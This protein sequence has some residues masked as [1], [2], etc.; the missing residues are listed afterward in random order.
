MTDRAFDPVESNPFGQLDPNADKVSYEPAQPAPQAA[1]A[2][3]APAADPFANFD[4]NAKD[5][6]YPT[7]ANSTSATGAFVRGAER[8]AL[9]ALGSFPAIGVG[10]EAGAAIGTAVFPGVGTAVGG[11]LGGVAGGL[12]AS[13]AIDTAQN[14]ALS[15]LPES[16]RESI[17]QS[18]RQ[19]Q[20][21]QKEH[22]TA[23]FLGG[24]LPYAVTMKPG[25]L[26]KTAELPENATALQHIMANPATARVFG[27]AVMGGMELGQEAVS[28]NP[29]DWTKVAISTGFGVVFNRPTRIGET[30]TE[31]GAQPARRALGRPEPVSGATAPPAGEAAPAEAPATAEAAPAATAPVRYGVD[32]FTPPAERPVTVADANDLGTMGPGV[33]EETFQGSHQR[34][35]DAR[36]TASEM[37]RTEQAAI[38][39]D[40]E[41]DIHHAARAM[42]P[43]LFSEYDDLKTQQR[44]LQEWDSPLAEAHL[45]ATNAELAE[46]E[47]QIAAAYRRSAEA[48]GAPIHE[49]LTVAKYVDDYSAGRGRDSKDYEQFA[50]NNAPEIEAEF[51]RRKQQHGSETSAEPI[52]EAPGQDQTKA[53]EAGGTTA[54]EPG[55]GRSI[56]DTR[57]GGIQYH[58]SSA[59]DLKPSSDHYSTL[60]YYGQGFYTTDAADVAHGYSKRGSKQTGERNIYE[61]KEKHPLKIFDGETS[62]PDDIRTALKRDTDKS[63]SELD[64][65][66]NDVLAENPKNMRELYDEIREQGT[67]EGLSADT[68]QEIFDGINATL[69]DLGYN[70]MSH[71]GG[72]RTGREPHRVVIYFDPEADLTVRKSTPDEFASKPAAPS[73]AAA[74]TPAVRAIE[75]QRDFIRGDVEKD[76]IA[77]GRPK[78]EAQAAAA[79]IAA[80]YEARA[81]RFQGKLG[82]P[83][84]LYNAEHAEILG[85]G[86]RSEQARPWK[87]RAPAQ[88]ERISLLQFIAQRGGIK[89][90]DPLASDVRST[91]GR[92]NKLIPGFGPLLRKTGIPL[93]R[94]RE[95]AVEAG[96]LPPHSEQ[97]PSTVRSLIDAIHDEEK[98]RTVHAQG[99]ELSGK[100]NGAER[101]DHLHAIEEEL[102]QGLRD[103]SIDPNAIADNVRTRAVEIMD[104]EHERDPVR[105]YEKAE[106][107]LGLFQRDEKQTES[108]EFKKWFAKSAVVDS[109]RTPKVLY[110]ASKEPIESFDA[111]KT[112]DG[113]FHFG[114]APQANM[115]V[116]GEG[117]QLTP[118]YLAIENPRRSKDT[119]GNWRSRIAAAKA[120]GNDGIVYLNRYEGTS[121]E[122]VNKAHEEGINLDKLSDG[123]FKKRFPE[124][125]DSYIAFEPEQIKSAIGNRGTF[126]PNSPRILEQATRGKIALL[127]GRRPIISLMKDANASTFIHETGHEWLEQMRRDA[128][129]E[130]AP[131][132]VK[133]D[134]ATINQWLG[135]EP[136]TENIPTKAHEKFARGFEQYLRE[137]IAPSP[138]LASVFARF[139]QWLTQIYQSLKGLGQ[140]I[141]DDIK[142]VFDRMLSAEPQRTVIA[143]ERAQRPTLTDIH[144][145][146]AAEASPHEADPVADRIYAEKSHYIDN[147]P[148]DIAR[149]H[150]AALEETARLEAEGYEPGQEQPGGAAVDAAG[151]ARPGGAGRAE[152]VGAGAEPDADPTSGAG[153]AQHG[154]V[155]PGRAEPPRESTPVRGAGERSGGGEESQSVPLAA[156]PAAD[157]TLSGNPKWVS[158]EGNIRVENL[159]SVRDIQKAV[160]ESATRVG[161]QGQGSLTA[162]DI[163]QLADAVQLDP[164]KIDEAQLAHLFG[165]V[166]N[167]AAKIIKLRQAIVQSATM[168]SDAMKAVRDDAS[169]ANAAA[170]AQ[171]MMRHDMLQSTLS[172]VTAETGRGLGMGF[173]NLEGWEKA[174]DLNAFMQENTGR[175]LF[176]LKQIAKLGAQLD[177]PGKISKYLRDAQKRSFGKMVLEYWI[178][179]LISG[180]STHVTYAIGNAVLAIE[181]AGPETAIAAALGAAR[182]AS[183]REG[184]RVHIGEVGAQFAGALRGLPGAVEAA[185][186]AIHSGQTTLLPGE[187]ARPL[188][189]FQ[190]DRGLT[191]A[192]SVTDDPVKWREVG[193]Q[194]FAM[195]RGIR[196]GFMAGAALLKAGGVEGAPLIG[197]VY[198]PLG[199]LPDLAIRGVRVLPGVIPGGTQTRIP[200]RSVAAIHSFFRSVGYSMNKSALAYRTAA[201]EGLT[202]TAFD[203]RVGEI[204]QDPSLAVMEASTGQTAQEAARFEAT[205]QTLMGQGGEMVKALG[206]LT[207]ATVDLPFIGEISPLKFV[208]P[209]VHIGA[210]I[211][212]QAIVQRTPVGVLSAEIRADLMGKNG[213]IAQDMAAARMLAG[214]SLALLFG[215]LAMQG[216]ASGSGPKE[217]AKQAMWKLAGNQAH[218][219]RIGDVWYDV[220]RLGP[221]GMLM[222]MA[223]DM[224]EV[225]HDAEKGEYMTAAAHLQHALTQNILDES[226][227]RGP[228]DL[229]KAIED[230]GRYGESYIRN[231][232]SSFVPFSVGI[233]QQARSMDP[234]SRQAR[235]VIDAMKAKIPGLSETLFP[236]R[237]IWGDEMQNPEALG[238]RGLTA[239]WERQVSSDPVNRAMLD[240][241]IAPAKVERKIRNVD[242]TDQQYDDYARIAGRMAKIRLD[243]I[244]KS[245]DYGA[246]PN[247]V[248][249]AVIQETIRQS[250]ESARGMVMMK[251]PQ[252]VKD[253]TE[254]RK[255]KFQD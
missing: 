137:G 90:D 192:K 196:D 140:P 149:E 130:A 222:G 98:G 134:S 246:W 75:Q 4:P 70:G 163:A 69:R 94:L 106:A 96:Y 107:E 151:E 115:R 92:D 237:D 254:A 55:S 144:L 159:T 84:E 156:T 80:R 146:D 128:E 153:G 219:V 67:S 242:L 176:Q 97:S 161:S 218:S 68:I 200:G 224:Y 118:V 78:E 7:D 205:Q 85:P 51:N 10:A 18:D 172:G 150:E 220:H 20:L 12:G 30:L 175:T 174:Q 119:G 253:A 141:N 143:P 232:L 50:A 73:V 154:A 93:D 121:F 184:P 195:I 65:L 43:E 155:Q 178:N 147:I 139:K 37:K 123:E 255:K 210:N 109:N 49:E 217:P 77:A 171:A 99:E 29:V 187:Q 135:I 1:P 181:K 13:Y 120:A 233:A 58:G 188:Q 57:G 61:V 40:P 52:A 11:L 79:L 16:W 133:Q 244:V 223:A 234:Y 42:H 230:P 142:Q 225:G 48:H 211:I 170:F 36:L 236:R 199:Q 105:A 83:E 126:D 152:V 76:L 212:K 168:V 54:A 41:V 157:L 46:I 31:W 47:P 162:G 112:V 62:I 202:G 72:L 138:E 110:H 53:P 127:E 122:N 101:D 6:N 189:P 177:T 185:L 129:H 207:N 104:Q 56:V 59:A 198:S 32:L 117:K 191:I 82:T 250:R 26:G 103:V 25:A 131:D 23:S 125:A 39:P 17:G 239:I 33:T 3:P 87:P 34:A 249:Q 44:Q 28:P 245:P 166:Q 180:V 251:W 221:M 2:K 241:G 100:E 252:I 27:G 145:A 63:Y 215:G 160:E 193:A 169:D 114:T 214:T 8:S 66:L 231:F 45:K 5:V 229:I 173:R 179:G 64:G 74:P 158:R 116:S 24:L 167:L 243:T 132:S 95:A 235:T 226:F 213:N 124:A 164:S 89:T 190:G 91:I 228:A 238:A 201:E 22:S 248:K 86:Q 148:E 71:Q 14:W 194:S 35:D 60:N 108:L 206:H 208:D 182:K 165:G 227:M 204:W 247:H 19:Q 183:G 203:S 216:Y 136:G 81:V 197:P 186:E 38:G 102:N 113:G 9:P 21:D 240:L 111:R 15:K 209:F 88:R